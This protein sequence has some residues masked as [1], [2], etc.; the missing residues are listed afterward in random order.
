MKKLIITFAVLIAVVFTSNAQ[1]FVGGGLGVDYMG[2]KYS[3]GGT[4]VD[5]PTGFA[6]NLTPKVGFYLNDDLA[7]GL[8]VGFLNGTLKEKGSGSSSQDEKFSLTGWGV[9]AFGRYRLVGEEKF[10]LLLEGSLG[11]SGAKT[12]ETYGSTTRNGDPTTTI[13]VGVLPVLSYS[14]TNRLNIEASCDFLRFGFDSYTTKSASNKDNKTTVNTFGFGV[15]STTSS[16]D[17]DGDMYFS[18]YLRVGILFKF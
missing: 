18:D 4:S 6:F 17:D 3:Y 2:G 16:I 7:I 12:K 5:L 14:L 13:S 8:E 1:V 9:G 10:S 15:N 11:V